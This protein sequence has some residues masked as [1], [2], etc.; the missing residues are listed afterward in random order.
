MA[1]GR[2]DR[3][4]AYAVAEIAKTKQKLV[5][6]GVDVIDLG[7]G[8]PDFAPPRIAV[9]ALSEA[10]RDPAMSRYGF[11]QGLP[12]FRES[13]AAYMQRRFEVETDPSDEVLP[14]IGSKEGL[15][16][17]ALATL[18]PGDVCVIPDPGY[19][20]YIGG[21]TFADA[22]IELYQ[23]RQDM[24]FL[25]ELETLGADR[26]SRTRLVYLN[27]PNNPTGASAPREYLERTVEIC[28]KYGT[29]L[30]FDNPYC[31][32]TYD[33]YVAPSIFEIEGAR[34]VALE[35]HSFSKSFGM[36]G[37]RLGWAC[38]NADLLEPLRRIKTY[39]DTGPF[40]ALQ[41]A[42][43][44][45]IDA[46]EACV[47][48]VKKAFSER[49]AA[50]LEAFASHDYALTEPQGA[51]YLWI[52]IPDNV[53]SAEL[54]N[55]LLENEGV[56]VL[57]G[58]ALGEG[59]EGFVRISFAFGPDRLREGVARIVAGFERLGISLART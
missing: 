51:M 35:F 24:D 14:L 5:S 16:H 39:M 4:P 47:A 45:V 27:Y 3:L 1:S 54:A 21:A 42:G 15:A 23:L 10:L 18:N 6:Q 31:E 29:L 32:L 38:G 49:R 56:A 53:R 11:Q 26:L 50:L 44:A 7:V 22:D 52:P 48:P 57:A 33:D 13:V 25:V 19:P 9:E 58:S 20:A 28:A 12:Q 41:K 36:T 55:S 43:A 46:S 34:E 59:G 30:A 8:D 37:W 2:I 17:L 40:L